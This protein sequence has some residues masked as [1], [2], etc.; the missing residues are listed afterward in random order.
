[1]S[2]DPVHDSIE[3][4]KDTEEHTVKAEISDDASVS[5]SSS[6]SKHTASLT[7]L[8]NPTNIPAAKKGTKISDLLVGPPSQPEVNV[9]KKKKRKPFLKDI[10]KD[11]EQKEYRSYQTLLINSRSRHLKKDDG[12]PYW[13]HEIQFEFLM[14]LFFNNKRA[15]KNPYYEAG[16]SYQWP[17]H[18]KWARNDDGSVCQNDG[19]MLTFFELYLITLLKSSKISKILKDRLLLDIN[20]ALNFCVICLLVNIGRLNTTVN[21]DY[22]MKSQF[23]TYHCIP[24]LQVGSHLPI[25][26]KYYNIDESAIKLRLIEEDGIVVT[27]ENSAKATNSSTRSSTLPSYASVR[28][29]S[30]YTISTVKQ[31]QDTP[32]IKSILKSINDLNTEIPKSYKEFVVGLSLGNKY[33]LNIVSLIFLLCVHEVEICKAFFPEPAE[34]SEDEREQLN[35]DDPV[36][37]GSLFND[38]WLQQDVRPEDKVDR[39]LWLIYLF[40]ETEFKSEKMQK[41]PFNKPGVSTELLE[42]N[43]N[44]EMSEEIA[45]NN[46]Y[47]LGKT[48][49]IVPELHYIDRGYR[50]ADPVLNDEDTDSE[51][52]FGEKMKALRLTF[53]SKE[54]SS[55]SHRV[56]L[57]TPPSSASSTAVSTVASGTTAV[58]S[59]EKES[60]ATE[61]MPADAKTVLS[62]PALTIAPKRRSTRGSAAKEAKK[63]SEPLKV[64]ASADLRRGTEEAGKRRRVS[65]RPSSIESRLKRRTGIESVEAGAADPY[66][67]EIIEESYEKSIKRRRK[68]GISLPIRLS[69]SQIESLLNSEIKAINSNSKNATSKRHRNNVYS[70]FMKDL[71][72]YKMDQIQDL[73]ITEG[74]LKRYSK[75]DPNMLIC[76]AEGAKVDE[77]SSQSELYDFGEFKVHY[78]KELNRINI[79]IDHMELVKLRDS[80]LKHDE[81]VK[82]FKEA[83]SFIDEAMKKL[84]D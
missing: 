84:D 57:S 41:N 81:R 71:L 76:E 21:F 9:T 23:R 51:K 18:F 65:V 54:Y 25:I 32:R 62:K 39:F 42:F 24:S 45:T 36:S 22:E 33:N 48:R 37:S 47:I 10:S 30:G 2:F 44:A 15:F 77:T 61:A 69:R 50:K 83:T 34:L 12:E 4:N 40:K 1:M 70:L 3:A 63:I 79:S 58:S 75:I 74:N 5:G 29:G 78:F 49:S 6:A 38:I 53:V 55:D 17:D 8:L 59:T 28:G 73:R 66:E 64:H 82:R 43:P 60:N 27:G 31:L 26:E 35:N 52:S 46:K 20:Y 19:K 80:K 7:S 68:N 67:L 56:E 11:A 16:V 13:R 14:R 72:D